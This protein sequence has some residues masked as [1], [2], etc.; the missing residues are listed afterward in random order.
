MSKR[1]RSVVTW[2]CLLTLTFGLIPTGVFAANQSDELIW[3]NPGAINLSKEAK[4]VPGKQGEW[5]ITLTVEG[6]NLTSGSSDVVLVLDRSGSMKGNPLKSMKSAAN[7]FIDNL[8][9]PQS[10]VKIALVSF[11]D[12]ASSISG[13]FK[14]VSQKQSLKNTVDG[15]SASGGTNIQAGIKQAQ[16][17][18]S[19]SSANNK[20]MVVLSD[21]EPTYSYKGTAAKDSSWKHNNHN[22]EITGFD[23]SSVR[24]SGSDYKL[25]EAWSGW[26]DPKP[27]YNEGSSYW[28][29]IANKY[30]VADNGIATISQARLAQKAG[31][32]IYSVGLNVGDNDNA[33]KTLK[34]VA[35]FD[36]TTNSPK[37]YQATDQDLQKIYNDVASEISF[38]AEDAVVTDP[39]GDMF[40]RVGSSNSSYT[41][42][43]GTMEWNSQTETFTWKIGNITEGNPATL[44]YRVVIDSSKNPQSDVLYPTNKTTT[45][46]YTDAKGKNTSK[47]FKVPQVSI[48]RG[49]IE[50][51]AYKVNAAGQPVN[52]DG[53]VVDRDKAQRL[54]SGYHKHN[55]N[56]ALPVGNSYNVPAPT[57]AAAYSDY[58]LTVGTNPTSQS[59]TVTNPSS[60]VW[61]GY[62]N[63]PFE[64]SVNHMVGIDNL[65][66]PTIATVKYGSTI[67]KQQV[68]I[69]GYTLQ[70]INISPN[71]SSLIG[72]LQ[73]GK[74][75]GTMPAEN[76]S[77]IFQYKANDQEVTIHHLEKGTNTKLEE[78]T[79]ATGKT[80][81]VIKLSSVVIPGY[82]VDGEAKVNYTVKRV[83]NEYTFYYTPNVQ[84]V[85]IRYLEKG[86]NDKLEE[87]TTVTG[88][89]G[90]TVTLQS[91]QINGYEVDGDAKVDYVVKRSGN[92]YT[93]YYTAA[94][95][96][97]T[98]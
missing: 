55:N 4:P 30:V 24:G 21:G 44:T 66:D 11:S 82:T 83:G 28:Y 53:D 52:A 51:I 20:I 74:V 98:V 56:E 8:L 39:M 35:S 26:W 41:I 22:Y 49:S 65:V 18:L 91:L 96:T 37:Y 36:T 3:P 84:E 46:H 85:T 43:Q 42:S 62:N 32:D 14:D 76:A 75:T 78:P 70:S 87:P 13:G 5:D 38:A 48:G 25:E 73:A 58:Y 47:E 93:F 64:L 57:L 2:L 61:F 1:F 94:D 33:K 89:T 50:V 9:I 34:D 68:N 88:K 19:G 54:Y 77:I 69:P 17:L 81:E 90:K 10:N 59:V 92:V 16:D 60:T 15:I 27:N 40:N 45:I 29:R 63:K 86:T 31:I 12:S 23:Y 72:N 95:Q 80:G 67:D 6:K 7:K 79:T 71:N 97:I